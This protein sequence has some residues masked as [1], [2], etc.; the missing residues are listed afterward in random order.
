MTL[1]YFSPVGYLNNCRYSLTFNHK[2]AV[3]WLLSLAVCFITIF[4]I[5]HKNEPRFDLVA[6]CATLLFALPQLRSAQPGIPT[7]PILLDGQSRLP[8]AVA[9]VS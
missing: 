4:V 7:T 3:A 8:V 5:W 9:Y 6:T 2:F 1:V